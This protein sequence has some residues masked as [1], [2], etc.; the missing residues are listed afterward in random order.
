MDCGEYASHHSD[1]VWCESYLN[2]S[3]VQLSQFL[4]DLWSVSMAHY[5][6]WTDAAFSFRMM[7]AN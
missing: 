2:V 4:L 6:V 3:T 5:L 7:T 1:R